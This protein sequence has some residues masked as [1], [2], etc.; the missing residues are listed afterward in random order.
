MLIPLIESLVTIHDAETP[1][2]SH[3]SSFGNQSNHEEGPT[4]DTLSLDCSRDSGLN[5][6]RYHSNRFLRRTLTILSFNREQKMVCWRSWVHASICCLIEA[7]K[8]LYCI[9]FLKSWTLPG[10]ELAVGS[11]WKFKWINFFSNLINI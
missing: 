5:E 9:N 11:P 4:G 6:V 1:M 3:S 8:E 7:I 10:R 2:P